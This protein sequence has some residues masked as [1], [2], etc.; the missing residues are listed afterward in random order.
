MKKQETEKILYKE[1]AV[2]WLK[3]KKFY[4]K[5]ST[6]ANY[7]NVIYRHLITDLGDYE[8]D[9]LSHNFLQKYI[10]DK[11]SNGRL[12]GKA[13]LSPKTV[14]DMM[15]VLKSTLKYAMNDKKMEHINLDFVY[16]N[17][18]RKSKIYVLSRREQNKMF[19]L[20]INNLTPRN[21]GI[22]LSLF[23][24]MRIGEICALKWSDIDLKNNIIHVNKTMQRIYLINSMQ[25][26]LTKVVITSPK[27][28]NSN[29]DIP[30]TKDLASMIRPLK[31]NPTDYVLTNN[32]NPLEPRTY[33]KYFNKFLRENRFR[34][35]NFHSLRHTFATNCINFGIDYK[36]V[37]ELL[38]HSN[39]SITLNLY[40]HPT[41]SQKKRSMDI[42]WKNCV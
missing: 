4:I 8:L 14:K 41:I 32:V 10:L 13:G 5:E 42:L 21:L 6:F 36:T 18:N 24:G 40:V 23:S 28:V 34:H 39:I 1:L 19:S 22:L 12:N 9:S 2:E 33:R 35:T 17:N 38:G 7:S 16:P 26:I 11:L 3:Y 15:T 27:T 29:R 20:V 30:I 37:S 31:K 25:D